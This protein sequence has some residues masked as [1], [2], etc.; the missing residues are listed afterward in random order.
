MAVTTPSSST[1][2][3][4]IRPRTSGPGTSGTSEGDAGQGRRARA[5]PRRDGHAHVAGTAVPRARPPIRTFTVGPGIP[6][7]Q[8]A[9]T[10]ADGSRTVTAGSE[11]HRPRSARAVVSTRLSL[12]YGRRERSGRG[13]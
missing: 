11:F 8:P 7:G 4:N 12:T 5:D 6:P 1:M 3:V 13:Q 10:R 2:P 9:A